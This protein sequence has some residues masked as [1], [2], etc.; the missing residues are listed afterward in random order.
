ML[1][2]FKLPPNAVL[3]E[4]PDPDMG[5]IRTRIAFVNGWA[6]SVVRHS[7]SYGHEEGL[8]ELAIMWNGAI[9]YEHPVAEGDVRGWLTEDDVSRLLAEIDATTPEQT[10][11]YTGVYPNGLHVR[12]VQELSL[13]SLDC[14]HDEGGTNP[15]ECPRCLGS[16]NETFP[17]CPAHGPRCV[18]PDCPE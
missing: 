1:V 6:A 5:G 12:D 2:N 14:G 16:D 7:F 9:N 8:W 13:G 15:D 11:A 17:P 10:F 3:T 18:N 4:F